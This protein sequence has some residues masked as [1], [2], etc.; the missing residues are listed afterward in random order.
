VIATASIGEDITERKRAD[1][2]IRRLNRVYEVLSQINAL[3]VRAQDRASLFTE[4]CRIAVEAGAYRMAWIGVIDP[5]TLDGKV[6][7]CH[8]GEGGYEDKISLTARDGTPDSERPACRALRQSQ[9]V[10]CNDLA[11]DPSMDRVAWIP[12]ET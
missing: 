5:N 10:I 6:I 7:A 8:G 11:N 1:I 9:P 12:Q 3:I 4:T 2:K